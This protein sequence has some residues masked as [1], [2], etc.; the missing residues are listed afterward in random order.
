MVSEKH[1]FLGKNIQLLRKVCATALSSI[2]GIGRKSTKQGGRKASESPQ[3]SGS[4]YD[5]IL[6]CPPMLG[7]YRKY[8]NFIDKTDNTIVNVFIF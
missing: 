5:I 8:G 6:G 1:V 3:I 2:D 4:I 7:R